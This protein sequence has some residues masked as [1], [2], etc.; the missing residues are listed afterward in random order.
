MKITRPTNSVG[1]PQK[2][3]SARESTSVFSVQPEVFVDR[4]PHQASRCDISGRV[5]GPR[6]RTEIAR[7]C[8]KPRFGFVAQSPQHQGIASQKR[9]QRLDLCCRHLPEWCW[10]AACPSGAI[11]KPGPQAVGASNGP[12]LQCFGDWCVR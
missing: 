3:N 6:T 2:F 12:P 11:Y 9:F 5:H 4:I 10:E 8:W 7:I 1:D